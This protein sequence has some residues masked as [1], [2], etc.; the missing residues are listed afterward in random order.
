[1][2]ISSVFH[3]ISSDS[4]IEEPAVKQRK[5]ATT[6]SEEERHTKKRVAVKKPSKKVNVT[7]HN[8]SH[9]EMCTESSD[10]GE[11]TRPQKKTPIKRGRPRKLPENE[12]KE[13]MDVID[14]VK[15]VGKQKGF[16]GKVGVV[17]MFT[18]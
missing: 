7:Y 11:D 18:L 10:S 3:H 17:P 12:L 14:L 2:P 8:K 4:E 5:Y 1:M 9:T 13:L 16:K 6:S 15:K